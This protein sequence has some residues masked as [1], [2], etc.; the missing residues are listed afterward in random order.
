[1]FIGAATVSAHRQHR[2]GTGTRVIAF[3]AAGLFWT[4]GG[5]CRGHG[6]LFDTLL[7]SVSTACVRHA[8]CPVV[9]VPPDRELPRHAAPRSETAAALY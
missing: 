9:V 5:S 6:K 1:M 2:S 4:A 7:G 8:V 3:A